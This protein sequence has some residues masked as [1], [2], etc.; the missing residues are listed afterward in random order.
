M[1]LFNIIY[2]HINEHRCPEI[3]FYRKN[4]PAFEHLVIHLA[5]M[6]G[7]LIKAIVDERGLSHKEFTARLNRSRNFGYSLYT[8]ESIKTGDLEMV[9]EVL[10]YNFFD[11]LSAKYSH[12]PPAQEEVHEP[13]RQQHANLVSFELP[14]A[15][16][17]DGQAR[18]DDGH[19]AHFGFQDAGKMP[20]QLPDPVGHLSPPPAGTGSRSNRI[21]G[22][23]SGRATR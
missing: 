21:A 2:V 7:D 3:S 22:S 1:F 15:D 23:A 17:L 8:S 5:P 14:E 4:S 13:R 11:H 18:V 10:K 9:C 19:P 6:L 20:A 12:F 16:C